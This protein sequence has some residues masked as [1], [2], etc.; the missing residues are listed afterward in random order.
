MNYEEEGWDLVRAAVGLII[1]SRLALWEKNK[2]VLVATSEKTFEETELGHK[3]IHPEFGRL[4]CRIAFA[5]GSEYLMKG[6]CLLN[7]KGHTIANKSYPVVLPPV[8][9]GESLLEWAR[10]VN[11]GKAKK[12]EQGFQT[13]GKILQGQ[14]PRQILGANPSSDLALAG[15]TLLN[16]TFR[17]RDAH[18]Y[19]KNKRAFHFY[20]VGQVL[21]PALN[22]LI[23][24]MDPVKLKDIVSATLHV[25]RHPRNPATQR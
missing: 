2:L 5:V 10:L 12:E 24:H 18:R 21:V 4:I 1:W 23:A 22:E 15:L 14:A 7:S 8:E 17:N 13:L 9:D 19:A 25:G 20:T 3:G 6:V 11:K 16:S